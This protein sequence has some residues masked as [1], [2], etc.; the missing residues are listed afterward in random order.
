[1]SLDRSPGNSSSRTD[2]WGLK[3]SSKWN[4]FR[5]G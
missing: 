5:G 4:E 1:M 2:D 3:L